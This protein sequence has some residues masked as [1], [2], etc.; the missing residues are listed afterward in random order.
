MFSLRDKVALITGSSR[1]IGRSI[2]EAMA[3]AGAKVV[4]SSRKVASCEKVAAEIRDGG[5]EA[6]AIPCKVSD[7]GQLRS[8]VDATLEKWEKIDVLV[9]NA[10][11]NPHF[12]SSQEIGEQAYDKIMSTNVKNVLWLCRAVIPQMAERKDGAVIIVTSIAG[13]KGT[14]KL[15]TYAL[16]KAAD[17]QMTRN[18]AIEWGA[19]NVRV[20]CIAPGLVRT[21]FARALWADPENCAKALAAYPLGRLGEPQDI[22]GAA[23][24]L[25]AKAASW[26]TGQ[27][28]VVDGG[29]SAAGGQYS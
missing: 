20:N 9:C 29:T 13:F 4:I 19:E 2:A 16:S 23:V 5:G 12:G 28:L 22:A 15:G 25:A 17:M 10:A 1:G 11:V 27:T 14:R 7:Q 21:D 3:G 18:L 6:I 8:L 24:F 26:I